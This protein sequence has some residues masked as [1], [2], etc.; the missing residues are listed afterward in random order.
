MSAILR[1]MRWELHGII[2]EGDSDAPAVVAAWARTFASR[3]LV[4]AEPHLR[5]RLNLVAAV[6][7][8]PPGPPDFS[9]GELLHYYVTPAG[10]TAHFPRFGQLYLDLTRGTTDGQ[11]VTEALSTYGVLEDLI[12]ISLSP[13]LRRRG[14]F[15]IHALAA[16]WQGRALLLVGGIGAG[17]TTTGLALLNAGWQLL[18]NDSPMVTAG[19]QVLSYPG[20]LAAYP[21]T[22]ARFATTQALAQTLPAPAGRQKVLAAAESLW[23]KVWR[24]QA[25]L[26]AILFPQI[27]ARAD[28]ALEPLT[29]PDALRRLLPHAVE[30]WDRPLIAPHL[31]ILRRLVEA[32]PAYL[33][34]LGPDVHALPARLA[35]LCISA[36]S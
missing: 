20:L 22:W 27:E 33:L 9:Q 30:Q 3:P 17:K 26:A 31:H 8:A 14:Y 34:R 23:P 28:H 5:C 12:A 11:I 36:D 16:A 13:H 4:A 19:A 10:V 1:R 35:P 7:T 6:P 2:I 29:P 32:A 18:S 15:L 24:E 21:E 25:P